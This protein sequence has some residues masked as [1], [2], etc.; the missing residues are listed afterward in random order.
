MMIKKDSKTIVFT[1]LNGKRK[2][3]YLRD[4]FGVVK[5]YR[6]LNKKIDITLVTLD[7]ETY[8][9]ENDEN[10]KEFLGVLDD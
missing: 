8:Y 1:L 3:F 6:V 9:L 5:Q 4:I 7:G 2:N 10:I